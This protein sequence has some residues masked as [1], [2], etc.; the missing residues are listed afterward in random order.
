MTKILNI[1]ELVHKA[2]LAI[3]VDGK[4]HEMKMPTLEDFI[5]NMKDLEA[6]AAAPN[7]VAETEGTVRMIA[8][9]FPTLTEEMVRSFPMAAIE[10]LFAVVRE[11]DPDAKIDA[12]DSEGNGSPAS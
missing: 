7:I 9:A 4:T 10:Q 5:L 8:R 2:P 1:D 3:R 11:A 12:E 6:M